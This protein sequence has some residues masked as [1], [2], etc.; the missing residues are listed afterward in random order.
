MKNN[1]NI[2]I[3]TFIL[4]FY[5]ILYSQDPIIVS[6]NSKGVSS[7]PADRINF[8]INL[9]IEHNE[10]QTA[11]NNH[12]K[13]MKVLTDILNQFSFPD[14]TIKFSLFY[15]NKRTRRDRTNSDYLYRTNQKVTLIITDFNKYEELQFA[16]IT[17][18]IDSFSAKFFSSKSY[19]GIEQATQNA[20]RVSEQ[21]MRTIAEEL[22]KENYTILEIE[23][24]QKSGSTSGEVYEFSSSKSRDTIEKIPQLVNYVV[25]VR[26][27]YQL[28]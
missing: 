2:L 3:F 28:N 20:I 8:K 1:L 13:Q 24:G 6:I 22:G 11:F 16:L 27:K 18:G 25:E 19:I 9:S 7:I 26:I 15:I 5:S 12:K 17:K 4:I 10:Y 23:V 21:K 14:S